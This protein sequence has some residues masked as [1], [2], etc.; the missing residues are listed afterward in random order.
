MSDRDTQK[1]RLDETEEEGAAV[2]VDLGDI[3]QY[4]TAEEAQAGVEREAPPAGMP[5]GETGDRRPTVE[6]FESLKAERNRLYEAWLRTSADFDN[7]RK[8][9]ERE[10]EE[11]RLYAMEALLFQMLPVLDN[12][13]RALGSLPPD[14][15]RGFAEG[16]TLIY[17]Q[18][19]DVLAKQ[20]LT[21]LST[22]N[23]LFDPHLH[24]AVETEAR[25][26]LPHHQ[27]IGE[28]Q[29][30]YRL[31]KRVLRPALVKVCVHPEEQ[32][33]T[34]DEDDSPPAGDVS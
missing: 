19:Q 30:G 11:F 4:E 32:G 33:N 14:M 18:L 12:F 3:E 15:P 9:T 8:R 17:K 13:E 23:E 5:A 7:Y 27:I 22:T 31:G 16:F 2:P 6:E 26:D 10:R 25:H 20:G 34:A 21:P 29:K 24:E 28:V 1:T